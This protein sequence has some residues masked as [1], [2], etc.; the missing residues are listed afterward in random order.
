MTTIFT[1]GYE[2]ATLSDFLATLKAAQ[3]EC[4]IDVRELPQS[5]RAG[6]SKRA[7][8]AALEAEQ[9]GYEHH[10][11]LG[12]PKPGRDAAKAGRF[13]EFRSIFTAHMKTK[14]AKDA[15]QALTP[16]L[17][18]QRCVLLCYERDHRTCHRNLLCYDLQRL[19]S[20]EIQHLGVQPVAR[21]GRMGEHGA[22]QH[23]RAC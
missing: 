8:S 16:T 20:F 21:S 6:F 17:K 5:R 4:V 14:A 10:R 9:I 1:I 12:D 18:K 3:V 19:G 22:E 2:G 23:A 15:L 11:Q 13:D 7:L